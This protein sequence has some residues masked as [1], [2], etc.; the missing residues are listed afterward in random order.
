M[1]NADPVGA[2]LFTG[3]NQNMARNTKEKQS[4]IVT[5]ALM[6]TSC[7]AHLQD[8][9]PFKILLLGIAGLGKPLHSHEGRTSG[10][11]TARLA[12]VF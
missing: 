10:T 3:L 5:Q 6:G 12:L 2:S 7:P 1:E 9:P 11:E 4:L 8:N